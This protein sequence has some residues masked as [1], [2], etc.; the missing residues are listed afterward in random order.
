MVLSLPFGKGSTPE[1]VVGFVTKSGIKCLTIPVKSPTWKIN[2]ETITEKEISNLKNAIPSN[3]EVTGLG[4]SWQN[5]YTMITNSEAEWERNLNYANK[6]CEICSTLDIQ[7]IV[8]GGPGRSVPP[9]SGSGSAKY[10]I[11]TNNTSRGTSVCS[12]LG[13]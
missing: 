2:P 10:R 9:G 1:E 13:G 7:H 6:L 12:R 3:V 11:T 5:E 4:F 8:L